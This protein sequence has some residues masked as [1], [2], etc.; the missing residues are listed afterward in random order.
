ML[1]IFLLVSGSVYSFGQCGKVIKISD[2]DTFI[3]MLSDQQKLKVRLA[4]IDCPEHDQDYGQQ[5]KDY[6]TKLLIDKNVCLQVKY[7]DPYKRAVSL[8]KLSNGQLLNEEMLKQGFAWHFTK[9]SKDPNLTRLELQA[10]K[11]HYGLWKSNNPVA[12]WEWRKAH[13]KRFLKKV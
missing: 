12:P 5:V 8:V 9:F 7:F 10:R 1:L 3:I 11:S 6:A 4:Y 2:G 13:N